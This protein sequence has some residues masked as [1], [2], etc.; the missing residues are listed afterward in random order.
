MKSLW[1]ELDNLNPL[2]TC[3][4][5]DRNCGLTKKSVEASIRSTPH[6]LSYEG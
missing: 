2:H 3:T 4:C 5:N 1:D 6:E